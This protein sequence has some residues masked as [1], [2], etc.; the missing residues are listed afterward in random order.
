MTV[1]QAAVLCNRHTVLVE[2]V[3]IHPRYVNTLIRKK[4]FRIS[5]FLFVAGATSSL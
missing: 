2:K 1:I 5:G 3:R 4:W